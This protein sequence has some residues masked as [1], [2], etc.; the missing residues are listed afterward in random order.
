MDCTQALTLVNAWVDGELTSPEEQ[1]A[2][3]AHLVGC[4]ECRSAAEHLRLQDADLQRAFSPLRAASDSLAQSVIAALEP[5]RPAPLR[6][7]SWLMLLAAT[8]AGYLIAI[9]TWR[10]PSDERQVVQLPGNIPVEAP[11]ARLAVATGPVEF[12]PISQ[13]QWFNCPPA[14]DL[15][16]GVAVRT[17][18]GTSCEVSTR[19][20]SKVRLNGDTEVRFPSARQVNLDRGQ[21]WS[22]VASGDPPFCVQLMDAKV[23][24]E[25]GKL[26]LACQPEGTV[27]TVIEGTARVESETDSATIH[28][29][30][31]A[32]ITGGRVSEVRRVYDTSLVTAWINELLAVKGPDDPEFTARLNDILAQL[33]Q[34]KLSY[35]YEEE[36]R[37][38]GDH[39]VLPLVRFLESSRS[40][41]DERKRVRAAGIVADVAQP[42]SIPLL[43]ELLADE[44]PEVRSHAARGLER[45]TSRDQGRPAAQWSETWASC[46]PTYRAWQEW[47]DTNRNRYPGAV[48]LK[49]PAMKKG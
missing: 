31:S 43:I 29:G 44:N 20:G 48:E 42:R 10:P 36:I 6:R 26:N 30:Q 47:W 21:L 3:D 13:V 12:Q 14:T 49:R 17:N 34:A 37:R 25:Q 33:G 39:C 46:A 15:A 1:A 18:P 32:T 22:S 24:A 7:A 45:L 38:L 2:L 8:A 35:L 41:G 4:A 16:S 9:F 19:D 40:Q 5:P 11:I 27:V 23:E 28:A